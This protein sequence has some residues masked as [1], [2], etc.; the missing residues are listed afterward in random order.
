MAKIIAVTGI[1]GS[2][3]RKFCERY[4]GEPRFGEK[5]LF[6]TERMLK[7][8]L[9]K[10]L[11]RDVAQENL[12]NLHED[13]LTT[14]KYHL[15]DNLQKNIEEISDKIERIII[16]THA[17]FFWDK[18]YRE[19]F[20]LGL[21]KIPVD[22]F[23]T[24]ID[25]PSSIRYR[26]LQTIQGKMQKHDLENLLLWQ[27][28]EAMQTEKM[29]RYL[30]KPHYIFSNKQSPE[31]VES[32]LDNRLLIYASFP[33]TDADEETTKRIV[34]FKHELRNL[35]KEIYGANELE[36]PLIDPAEID[37]ETG[38]GLSESEKEAIGQHTIYR[39]LK[40]DVGKATHTIAYYPN[41]E[42]DLSAGVTHECIEAK[43]TGKYAY[44]ITP[45]VK[46]SP[47]LEFSALEQF[48]DKEE[49]LAFFKDKI[50][51]DLRTY[52]RK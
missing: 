10:A 4:M 50:V 26:Q 21:S 46:K 30:R 19:G 28:I 47:F 44:L 36:I 39:D 42:T 37:I 43:Q 27:Q 8:H 49:F 23:V 24:I 35:R 51:E 32:L 48:G 41:A 17:V 12:L 20:D 11:R 9:Q 40:W 38:D 14:A 45:R 1:S 22:M 6:H 34:S 13:I 5:K 29:A 33:M 2:G 52:K 7:E 25:K 3:S 18:V 15:M 16:D 31:S